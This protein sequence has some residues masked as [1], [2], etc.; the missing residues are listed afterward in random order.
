MPASNKGKVNPAPNSSL[1]I[2]VRSEDGKHL[3]GRISLTGKGSKD[4][5]TPAH[6]EQSLLGA[7]SLEVLSSV[8]LAIEIYG[9][10]TVVANQNLL[11]PVRYDFVKHDSA[12]LKTYKHIQN[13][14][15]L[16]YDEEWMEYHNSHFNQDLTDAANWHNTLHAR[17]IEE[18]LSGKMSSSIDVTPERHHHARDLSEGD[19]V[20]WTTAGD[21]LQ[22]AVAYGEMPGAMQNLP[23]E[24]GRRALFQLKLEEAKNSGLYDSIK[25][26]GVTEPILV[27]RPEDGAEEGYPE[28]YIYDGFHRLSSAVDIDLEMI[29]PFSWA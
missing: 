25:V 10:R 29:V 4:I 19:Y 28:G 12:G 23:K 20:E 1:S 5:P 9:A 24:E 3:N 18:I 17:E 27:I 11:V 16:E 7:Q 15:F 22:Y 21:L 2:H 13:H 26:L 14:H 6:G 8:A